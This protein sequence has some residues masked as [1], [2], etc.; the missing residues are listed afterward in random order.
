MLYFVL[1]SAGQK[2]LETGD[3]KA[4]SEISSNKAEAELD[5]I[6]INNAKL[7]LKLVSNEE[8]VR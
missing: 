5:V 3:L 4:F 2:A 6:F 1:P 7:L 8:Q